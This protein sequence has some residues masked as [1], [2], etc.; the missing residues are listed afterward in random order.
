MGMADGQ[1]ANWIAF[2]Q[3][4]SAQRIVATALVSSGSN[5]TASIPKSGQPGWWMDARSLLVVGKG[6]TGTLVDHITSS[7]IGLAL[8]AFGPVAFLTRCAKT[9]NF[10]FWD[11]LLHPAGAC[12]SAFSHRPRR[13]GLGYQTPLAR[14]QTASA[15][16]VIGTWARWAGRS[17]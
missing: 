1:P 4:L 10:S 5:H 14:I 13:I 16:S 3:D 9:P 2:Q 6:P 17:S 7:D 15:G 12:H 8:Q 11:R